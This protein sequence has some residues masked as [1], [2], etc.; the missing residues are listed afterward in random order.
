MARVYPEFASGEFLA[1]EFAS[2]EIAWAVEGA[3]FGSG[4][5]DFGTDAVAVANTTAAGVASA[6]VAFVAQGVIGSATN[7]GGSAVAG[8]VGEPVV[9]APFLSQGVSTAAFASGE[10]RWATFAIA[11][12]GA[13]QFLVAD[14]PGFDLRSGTTVSFTGDSVAAADFTVVA[15]TALTPD[16]AAIASATSASIGTSVFDPL[17]QACANANG[18]F[19]GGS[20]SDIRT[21]VTANT[22]ATA[23][24]SAEVLSSAQ[25]WSI[26][27]AQMPGSSQVAFNTLFFKKFDARYNATS[28]SYAYFEANPLVYREARTTI[29]GTGVAGAEGSILRQGA[30]SIA[31]TSEVVW[32]RGRQVFPSLV[33]SPD[34]TERPEENRLVE[35]PE[36]NRV[37]QWV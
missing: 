35:R 3:F 17:I 4:Q 29:H 2:D 8:F 11:G 14:S 36:E 22:D 30:T 18:L 28:M 24:G 5:G 6:A 37:A 32:R 13:A 33:A 23:A 27:T 1:F 20:A 10:V 21:Q 26:A 12:A 9:Q 25:P 34:A 7:I 16:M 31:G 15:G 19:S